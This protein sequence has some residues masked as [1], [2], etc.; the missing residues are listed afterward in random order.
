LIIETPTV[1]SSLVK[2]DNSAAYQ[3]TQK[4]ITETGK[5]SALD[6]IRKQYQT[7][8]NNGNAAVNQSL[9]IEELEKAWA[10]YIQLL[11]DA[12]NPA[13][14]SFQLALL[15]VKDENSFEA[16]TGNNIEKQ[17]VEQ[18]RNK[19]FAYLQEALKNKLLQYNVIIE[20][21]TD[22]RP[23]VEIPLSSKEQFLKMAEQYP[24]VKE[25][26]DRLRLELDY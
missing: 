15:R 12:K 22:D 13:V 6:K 17:F 14:P 5:L 20:E 11:K 23:P 10:G 21:K 7:N 3:P 16:V 2:E 1:T 18:E 19:L 8:G 26:K 4:I 9:Q 25:M 24:L